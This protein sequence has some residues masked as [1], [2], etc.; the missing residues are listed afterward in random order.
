MRRKS[1]DL[2]HRKK[3][4]IHKMAERE[5]ESVRKRRQRDRD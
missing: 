4:E 3:R 2:R 1:K 5:K